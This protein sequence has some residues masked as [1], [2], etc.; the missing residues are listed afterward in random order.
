[1]QEGIVSSQTHGQALQNGLHSSMPIFSSDV[2]GL[3]LVGS[4]GLPKGPTPDLVGPIAGDLRFH[5]GAKNPN[6]PLRFFPPILGNSAPARQ[7][8]NHVSVKNWKRIARSRGSFPQAV[9]HHLGPLRKCKSDLE[10]K[11]WWRLQDSPASF[12]ESP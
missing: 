7:G 6:I 2:G 4:Q 11:V 10:D 1:M 12:N 5:L 8:S 3:G 9:E